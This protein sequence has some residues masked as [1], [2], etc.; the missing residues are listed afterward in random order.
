M[1]TFELLLGAALVLALV[2]MVAG[3]IMGRR[4][5]LA[6]RID[7]VRCLACNR[8]RIP[9]VINPGNGL[10]VQCEAEIRTLLAGLPAELS[11]RHPP[12]EA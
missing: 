9:Q 3:G 11:P 8:P 5:H 12:G 1:T 2:A 4:P 10:C 6:D 7:L